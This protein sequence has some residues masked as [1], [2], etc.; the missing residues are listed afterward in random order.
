ML[1]ENDRQETT[2]CCLLFVVCCWSVL[3]GKHDREQVRRLGRVRGIFGTESFTPVEVVDL[4]E[5]ALAAN[6]KCAEIMFA[7]RVVLFVELLALAH[8]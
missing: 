4:P 1:T 2:S 5:V 8:R 3:F 7:V 6:Y